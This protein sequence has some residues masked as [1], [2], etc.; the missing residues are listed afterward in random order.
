MI[1]LYII[2]VMFIALGTAIGMGIDKAF[3]ALVDYN[4]KKEAEERR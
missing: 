1:R 3:D 2:F 4:L